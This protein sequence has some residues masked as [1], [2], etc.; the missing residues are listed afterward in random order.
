MNAA[1]RQGTLDSSPDE[2]IQHARKRD[3]HVSPWKFHRPHDRSGLQRRTG[4]SLRIDFQ[5]NGQNDDENRLTSLATALS[6]VWPGTETR[7]M[8]DGFPL[9]TQRRDREREL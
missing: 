1:E 7:V 9:L 8:A 6:P 4:S 2:R 3:R 5:N